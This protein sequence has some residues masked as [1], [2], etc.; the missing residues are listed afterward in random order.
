VSGGYSGKEVVRALR[1]IGFS[2]DHQIGSHMFMH[3][4]EK[5]V[6][7]VVPSHKEIKKSTLH[8]IIKKAGITLNELKKLV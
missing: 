8:S 3:N 2:I 5:N 4:P 7:I 6:Y 1:K